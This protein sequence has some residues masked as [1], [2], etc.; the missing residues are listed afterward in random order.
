M[1]TLN[2]AINTIPAEY[3]SVTMASAIT[4]PISVSSTSFASIATS[5][6][7]TYLASLVQNTSPKNT[8]TLLFGVSMA[9]SGVLTTG[10]NIQCWIE[11]D[12]VT[13]V[14]PSISAQYSVASIAALTTSVNFY[15]NIPILINDIKNASNSSF[16]IIVKNNTGVTLDINSMSTFIPVTYLYG[17]LRNT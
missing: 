12:Q 3:S 15:M 5:S 7:N 9:I 13:G 16:S 1:A 17:G 6:I 10:G 8:E 14:S 2:N 11:T 4:S